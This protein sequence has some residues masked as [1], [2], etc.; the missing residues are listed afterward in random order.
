MFSN[1][2]YVKADV[3]TG[4]SAD[5]RNLTMVGRIEPGWVEA[6]A[7]TEAA[8]GRSRSGETL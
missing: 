5:P 1:F 3:V 7:F 4:A 8:I 2:E 6:F